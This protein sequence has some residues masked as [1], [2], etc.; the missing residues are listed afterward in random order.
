[1]PRSRAFQLAPPSRVENTPA[2]S[3]P[4]Y[5]RPPPAGSAASAVARVAVKPRFAAVQLAPPS[6]LRN[7]PGPGSPANRTGCRSGLTANALT[8]ARPRSRVQWAPPSAV[9]KT[10]EP[11]AAKTEPAAPGKA[12]RLVTGSAVKAVGFQLTPPLA[13]VITPARLGNGPPPPH[14]AEI[15]D[16]SAG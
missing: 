8:V 1:M 13:L 3:V 2:L 11:V 7:T 14:P 6:A 16:G 4:M 5:S 9:R 10:P 12:A 15:L